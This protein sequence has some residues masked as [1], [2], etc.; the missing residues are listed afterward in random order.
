M[1][2]IDKQKISKAIATGGDYLRKKLL[3]GNYGLSCIGNDGSA[4]FSNSKG[5]LFSIFHIVQA[6]KDEI[7]ELER[8]IF[9]TRILSEEYEGAWGYSPRGYY[10]QEGYNPFFVD[11]DDTSF[12]LRTLRALNV[13]RS[14]DVLMKFKCTFVY[15]AQEYYGFSTFITNHQN[16]TLSSIPSFENNFE[17]HPEVNA[18]VFH[19][20]VFADR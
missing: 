15:D 9:L 4:K 13:Y 19:L 11:S 1:S 18:N 20:Q 8:T 7:N 17:I 6:L 14:N 10:K 5:H 2:D 3:S 16:R 12:A